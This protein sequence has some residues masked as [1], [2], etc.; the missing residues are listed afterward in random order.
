MAPHGT[1]ILAGD[2][3]LYGQGRFCLYKPTPRQRWELA[4]RCSICLLATGLWVS[5]LLP[6]SPAAAVTGFG[7]V[8]DDLYYSE[9]VQW[10]VDNNIVT[11]TTGPCFGPHTPATRGEA[12]LY[13]WRME[14]QPEAPL[15]PFDD[16][17]D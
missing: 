7:D 5:L 6:V 11:E 8:D 17:T 16:V 10:M 4:R 12:A 14:D 1:I 2:G 13:M 15:H 3:N 9:P